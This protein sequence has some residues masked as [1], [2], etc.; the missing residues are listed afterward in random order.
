[1]LH[2]KEYFGLQ[3]EFARK[4]GEVT[5]IP[6]TEAILQYTTCYKKFEIEGWDF[7]PQNP[8]WQEF[9]QNL[10]IS[11]D[12]LDAVYD[13]YLERHKQEDEDPISPFGCFS[14]DYKDDIHQVQI[15]FKQKDISGTGPL[16]A[17]RI[18]VRRA[19]LKKLFGDVKA[20]HPEATTVKGLSWLYGIESYKR[21]FPASYTENPPIMKGWFKS[22]AL[23]GQFVNSK[24]EVKQDMTQKFLE[25]IKTKDTIEDLEACFPYKIFEPV[26]DIDDFYKFYNL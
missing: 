16:G 1:M 8:V 12:P 5:N 7:N 23:W 10:N 24:K 26:G 25:C 19:E 4:A 22:Y 13:F 14:Y 21:L 9:V 18:E 6:L 20:K 2:S 17:D 11:T 15:H 3:L